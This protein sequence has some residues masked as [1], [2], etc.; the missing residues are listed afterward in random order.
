MVNGRE[1][2]AYLN[3]KKSVNDDLEA[4]V[5][6]MDLSTF[7]EIDRIDSPENRFP[8][9]KIT[10]VTNHTDT[11]LEDEKLFG[12]GRFG[13]F[14][15]S[16]KQRKHLLTIPNGFKGFSGLQHCCEFDL[17]MVATE[18]KIRFMDPSNPEKESVMFQNQE[19]TH[20][21]TCLQGK[22]LSDL[23]ISTCQD[24][25]DPHN[26]FIAQG[27]ET[28]Q[29]QVWRLV[30]AHNDI[31]CAV[32]H[33]DS[34]VLDLKFVQANGQYNVMLSLHKSPNHIVVT[35]M[36]SFQQIYQVPLS[37]EVKT[38]SLHPNNLHV[39][40]TAITASG[41]DMGYLELGMRIVKPR[42][43]SDG[44]GEAE[45]CTLK[46]KELTVIEQNVL[47]YLKGKH[48][49]HDMFE[50]IF[51]ANNNNFVIDLIHS[52]NM[53]NVAASL[54]ENCQIKDLLKKELAYIPD[55]DGNYPAKTITNDNNIEGIN[56]LFEYLQQDIIPLDHSIMMF[57]FKNVS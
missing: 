45:E 47:W 41:H 36:D 1:T 11:N 57:G 26:K 29:I 31:P 3:C 9:K 18:N 30:K 40:F 33:Y 42:E 22:H 10:V 51:Q 27:D 6:V 23:A 19:I 7:E 20:I 43:G 13:L 21:S 14:I 17:I 5:R 38:L 4:C 49:V 34:Q 54:Q 32:L 44:G 55:F 12:I 37:F 48:H 35:N 56:N 15:Y 25:I 46:G 16:L 50:A 28:G 53:L 52:I 2:R 8:F 24:G 39:F